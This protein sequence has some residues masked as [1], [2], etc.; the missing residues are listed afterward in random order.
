MI[1]VCSAFATYNSFSPQNEKHVAKR[2]TSSFTLEHVTGRSHHFSYGIVSSS[3]VRWMLQSL[4]HG[5]CSEARRSG[6]RRGSVTA[7][8]ERSQLSFKRQD[9]GMGAGVCAGDCFKVV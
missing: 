5:W 4:W 3:A 8:G 9:I 7:P 6:I 1:S 2:C